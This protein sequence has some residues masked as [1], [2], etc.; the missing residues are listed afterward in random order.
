MKQ[1]FHH[2]NLWE[3]WKAGMWGRDD[4]LQEAIDFTGDHE[5]YGQAMKEVT[6]HW[7]YACEHNLSNQTINRRAWIGH[8]AVCFKLGIC[9]STTR[10]AWAHL[11][12]RQRYLANLQADKNILAW[13]QRQKS[14]NTLNSGENE[15][16]KL[17][18]QTR[19]PLS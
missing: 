13:E 2:Y 6:E 4:R 3:D 19:L 8:A 16:T 12:D 14:T 7:K 10:Q 11:N 18:Y 5:R 1:I 9:E 17:I 15:A